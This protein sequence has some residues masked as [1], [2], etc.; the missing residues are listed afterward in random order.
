VQRQNLPQRKCRIFTVDILIDEETWNGT[1]HL[2]D[3]MAIRTSDHNGVRLV[4]L[5]SLWGDWI[6]ATGDPEKPD[7]L[8][9]RDARRR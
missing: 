1:T 3:D 6:T 7:E 8:F 4:L 5:H 9:Q 2:P